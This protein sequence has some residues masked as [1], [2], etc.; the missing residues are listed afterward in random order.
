M[1]S[2]SNSFV[3]SLGKRN[4]TRKA[5]TEDR[6][7]RHCWSSRVGEGLDSICTRCGERIGT[8]MDELTLL[9]EESRHLC[10]GAVATP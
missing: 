4:C 2:E 10:R 5:T 7:Y 6:R 1:S 8:N 3:R 9:T